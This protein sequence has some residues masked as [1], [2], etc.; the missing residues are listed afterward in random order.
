MKKIILCVFIIFLFTISTLYSKDA[1]IVYGQNFA[2]SIK[3]PANWNGYTEDAYKYTVN[4]YFCLSNSNFNNSPAVIYI[5]I[6]DKAGY[7]VKKHLEIDMKN[8]KKK[9]K[10]I[11]FK[12]FKINKLNYKFASKIYIIDDKFVD[13]L[14]YLDP[15]KDSSAYLIFVLNGKKKISKKYKKDFIKIIK[16]FFWLGQNVI[17]QEKK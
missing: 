17:L 2:F 16:S 8:F 15:G 11:E 10:K 6:L 9:K 1:M 4:A 5:R 7:E 3:E 12:E 14:C 13:Y